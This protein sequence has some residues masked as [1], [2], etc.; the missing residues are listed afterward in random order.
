MART[1]PADRFQKLVEAATRTFISRGY[2]QT[3]MAHVAEALGV[4]KGTVYG[5]VESK[6]ALFDAAIRFADGHVPLPDAAELPL[7]TPAPGATVRLLEERIAEEAGGLALLEAVQVA[8]CGDLG[9]ELREVLVDL[10]RRAHRNRFAIKLADRCSSEYPDLADVWFGRG[11]WAQHEL[12]IQY[13]RARIE[14]GSMRWVPTVPIAARA[15]LETIAFW[16]V[17]RHWDPSPQAIDEATLEDA[18]VDLL[19]H[20]LIPER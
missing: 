5:Y 16:A 1:I 20:S 14:A 19:V 17:H 9:A 15:V 2:R 7:K 10:Y 4:A 11:R 3:Q 6:A 12:L 8:E 18:V 13:M